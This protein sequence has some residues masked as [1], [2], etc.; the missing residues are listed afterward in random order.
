MKFKQLTVEICKRE[1]REGN[2]IDI[3]QASGVMKRAFD[4]GFE[5]PIAFI[6][7]FCQE[8]HKR[9]AIAKRAKPKK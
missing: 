5:H 9:T 3:T 6:Y 2:D 1:Q 4:I 8:C 7:L